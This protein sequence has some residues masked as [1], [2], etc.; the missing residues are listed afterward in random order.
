M[1][2]P[3]SAAADL[4]LEAGARLH[5]LVDDYT[6]PWRRPET[7]LMLHGIAEQGAI[8]RPC[9]PHFA[10]D[11]RV[12]RPD[13]RGFGVSS[14]LPTDRPFGLSEWADDIERL[15]AALEGE[16]VHLVAT[17]LGA[18]VAFELAQRRPRWLAS[19]TLA[20]MLASPSGSL[21]AW[22]A[23]WIELV[24]T[25]GVEGWA[26]ATMPGRM[27]DAL[28]PAAMEWWIRLM[29]SA[30]AASVI[31]CFR[32]LPGIEGPPGPERVACPTLFLAAGG[33]AYVA[34]SYNQRPAAADLE[35][36]KARVPGA[37]LASIAANSYHFA[38]TH[39]D[40]CAVA[41]REFIDS[42]GGAAA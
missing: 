17:K 14:A 20:G 34:E 9:V 32:L 19:M 24:E 22:V 4:A 5:Y 25:Q 13:L 16:R 15:V 40:A 3:N 10:R 33:E 12:V 26:R 30:P 6:D 36:L 23:E 21:G 38:A 39:P 41:T 42:I 7:A 28:L 11:Y 31:H 29:G 37:R 2:A 8:W 35:R 18:L 1:S 27:G